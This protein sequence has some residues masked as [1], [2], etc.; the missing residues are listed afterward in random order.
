MH[1]GSLSWK[2]DTANKTIPLPSGHDTDNTMLIL[3]VFC[4]T[5]FTIK[6]LH[7]ELNVIRIIPE[8]TEYPADDRFT[9]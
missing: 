7:T 5:G 4:F 2:K 9:S 6:Y 1:G 3:P 8:L